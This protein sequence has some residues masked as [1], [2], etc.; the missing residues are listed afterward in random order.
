MLID[1]YSAPEG[2]VTTN[3]VAVADVTTAFIFPKYTLLRLAVSLKP[4]PVI[5]TV[6]SNGIPAIGV[7]EVIDGTAALAIL[8]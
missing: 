7:T 5:T 2:I 1:P 3:D 8:L 4:V 6:L